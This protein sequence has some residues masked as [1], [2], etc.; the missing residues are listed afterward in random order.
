[1]IFLQGLL[2]GDSVKQQMKEEKCQF[3]AVT[4]IQITKARQKILELVPA[5]VLKLFPSWVLVMPHWCRGSVN[6]PSRL[7]WES[8][9][10]PQRKMPWTVQHV[11]A[12]PAGILK[13]F[14]MSKANWVSSPLP[15]A[16]HLF[17]IYV[18]LPSHSLLSS[19]CF[20][21]S[22]KAYSP[23][24]YYDTPNPTLSQKQSKNYSYILQ[25]TQKEPDAVDP[26]LKYR[27]EVR[28]VRSALLEPQCVLLGR[29]PQKAAPSMPPCWLRAVVGETARPWWTCAFPAEWER[30][31]EYTAQCS[32]SQV[33]G[34]IESFQSPTASPRTVNAQCSE[35]GFSMNKS[36]Q[37][38]VGFRDFI[39]QRF[40]QVEFYPPHLYEIKE[41]S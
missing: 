37:S 13:G 10:D 4:S 22:A 20:F 40:K 11:N 1:M 7:G 25:W 34:T 29:E 6:P 12:T 26:I 19:F 35:G 3:K 28:Q 2:A 38:L 27:L 8:S 15:L 39:G 14:S 32:L 9:S 23:E 21:P 31:A 17:V 5:G 24:F 30:Q 36:P 41:I 16:P 33:L 18:P